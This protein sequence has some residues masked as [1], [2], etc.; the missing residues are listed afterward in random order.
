MKL[1][2]KF[3]GVVTSSEGTA[4][5]DS[6]YLGINKTV[7]FGERQ[8]ETFIYLD[9]IDDDVVEDDEYVLVD[10]TDAENGV[11]GVPAQTRVEIKNDDG[12][13]LQLRQA[14]FCAYII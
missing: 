12:M 14:S 6:D 7:T 3:A 8:T 9:V 10:L 11:I 5:E 13:N 1:I 4:N 2:M